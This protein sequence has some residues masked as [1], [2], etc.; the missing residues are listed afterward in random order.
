MAVIAAF[1]GPGLAAWALTWLWVRVL[2]NEMLGEIA[3]PFV[4]W[5]MARFVTGWDWLV[6]GLGLVVWGVWDERVR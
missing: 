3:P 1:L 5:Q 4:P 6:I 2:G